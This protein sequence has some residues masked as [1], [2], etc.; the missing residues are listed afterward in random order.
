MLRIMNKLYLTTQQKHDLELRHRHCQDRKEGDRIKAVLLFSEG[1]SAEMI[2]QA[3]RLDRTTIHRHVNDFVNGKYSISSGGS[4]SFLSD[5]QSELLIAHLEDNTYH[6]VHE[7]IEYVENTFSV[8]YSIPGMNKWLHRNNF[9]YKKPKGRPYKANKEQQEQFIEEY[10]TLKRELN[11]EDSVYFADSVHPTQASKLS[12]GWIRK[13]KN[14]NLPTTASRT[15]LNIIGAMK[16]NDIGNTITQRYDTINSDS[17]ISHLKLLRKSEG[18]NGIIY[19]VLDQAPYH[20]SEAVLSEAKK[21]DIVLKFLPPYSPNLN[22]IERLWKVMNEKVRNNR[23]FKSAKDFK[24]KIDDFFKKTLPKIG[25]SL[26]H[27]I[28]DNFQKF[29]NTL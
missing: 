25:G 6:Y 10:N 17:I 21:L 19:L 2:S 22:P 12:Y 24:D 3:L 16:L 5:E 13:G 4:N 1:W 27:R 14:K 23:F 9:S 11:P 28:T 7:I 18:T 26:R 20:R 15:R 8:R 29:E